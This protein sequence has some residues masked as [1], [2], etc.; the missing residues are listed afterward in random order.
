MLSVHSACFVR[1][2]KVIIISDFQTF[3]YYCSDLRK[4][5]MS[6]FTMSY[7][8]R[9]CLKY[10]IFF[11]NF[12]FALIGLTLIG[13]GSYLQIH[14]R[15]YFDFLSNTFINTPVVVIV[16]G[17]ERQSILFDDYVLGITVFL[18][19]FLACFG[20]ISESSFLIFSYSVLLTFILM[21]QFAGG[22]TAFIMKKNLSEG[23]RIFFKLVC[24]HYL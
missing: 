10:S 4:V 15:H 18:I 17:L 13:I 22:I 6:A 23:N 12:L 19:S 5:R 9:G 16:L 11:F 8:W 7:C 3:N 24:C 2:L 21:G 20:A 1:Q 14:A